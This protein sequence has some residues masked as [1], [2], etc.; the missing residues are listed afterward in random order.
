MSP[1]WR[2][3]EKGR[4]LPP[5]GL[6]GS[7]KNPEEHHLPLSGSL[8]LSPRRKKKYYFP[9]E[10]LGS[11]NILWV[12]VVAFIQTVCSPRVPSGLR[13][14]GA[15][16]LSFSSPGLSGLSAFT[17]DLALT[18]LGPGP[19]PHLSPQLTAWT[20]DS[21]L[22]WRQRLPP[23][24]GRVFTNYSWLYCVFTYCSKYQ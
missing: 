14:L 3:L 2:L 20:C 4:H 15:L 5:A 23:A 12:S 19:L 21:P 9:V 11:Q 7:W 18:F 16:C 1:V 24:R 10:S 22:C 17:C 13:V 8:W 6:V